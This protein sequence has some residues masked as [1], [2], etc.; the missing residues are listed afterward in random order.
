MRELAWEVAGTEAEGAKHAGHGAELRG[1]ERLGGETGFV[2]S[3]GRALGDRAASRQDLGED[4]AAV[5]LVGDPADKAGLIEPIDRL[6]D[7]G[8]VDLQALAIFPSGS[9]P[10]RE[11]WRSISAS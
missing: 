8:P 5:G 9:D 11:R 3:L 10:R 1:R 2:Q 6:G 4:R 7:A